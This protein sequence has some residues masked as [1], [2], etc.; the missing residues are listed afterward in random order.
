MTQ[1][2]LESILKQIEEY[3]KSLD[4]FDRDKQEMM[5]V[6]IEQFKN[7]MLSWVDDNISIEGIFEEIV[8]EQSES[9]SNFSRDFHRLI[10]KLI[11]YIE[12][13]K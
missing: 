3:Q 13:E 1:E 5:D 8:E 10:E 11:K 4:P 7:D 6:I 9:D 12:V 2:Q